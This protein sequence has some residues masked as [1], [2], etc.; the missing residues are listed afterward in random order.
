MNPKSNPCI[1]YSTEAS[2]LVEEPRPERR[3]VKGMT[4]GTGWRKTETE[5]PAKPK[6]LRMECSRPEVQ[7]RF[8]VPEQALSFV[9]LLFIYYSLS[10]LQARSVVLTLPRTLYSCACSVIP[11]RQYWRFWNWPQSSPLLRNYYLFGWMD[12]Y[13]LQVALIPNNTSTETIDTLYFFGVRD[14]TTTRSG[15]SRE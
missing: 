6:P 4:K 11:S 10:L 14:L 13:R 15:K 1:P 7:F 8:R 3:K 5:T 12:I 9:L 2:A